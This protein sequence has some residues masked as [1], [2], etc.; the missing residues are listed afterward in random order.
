M[1]YGDGDQLTLTAVKDPKFHPLF[2][3]MCPTYAF[4]D[5]AN[6]RFNG[7]M[8]FKKDYA[9]LIS[10]AW[11][12]DTAFDQYLNNMDEDSYRVIRD[13][14]L[15]VPLEEDASAEER[16]LLLEK[17]AKSNKD[18]KFRKRFL[19]DLTEEELFPN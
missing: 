5:R 1:N 8:D 7:A 9:A 16:R 13:M 12:I 4:I 14:G 6:G 11:E 19:G 15:V 10:A 18:N 3:T 17:L 2:I